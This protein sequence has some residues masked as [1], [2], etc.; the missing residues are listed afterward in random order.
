[1][2]LIYIYNPHSAKEVEMLEAIR[3]EVG[4]FVESLQV[5]NL[6][7][8]RDKYPI[9][10]TPAIIPICDHWQGDELLAVNGEGSL[11]VKALANKIM[12]EEDLVVHNQ[13]T[14]RLDNFVNREKTQ[15]ID[16][17]T[18]ELIEGGIV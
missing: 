4:H 8:V 3:S 2:R 5:E 9:R 13:E 18:L 6:I 11:L 14:H 7:D 16:E 12:E 10:A 15:A 17:Y 1:M